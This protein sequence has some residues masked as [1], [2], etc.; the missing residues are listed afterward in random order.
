MHGRNLF[1]PPGTKN[2]MK[3]AENLQKNKESTERLLYIDSNFQRIH[4]SNKAE[5]EIF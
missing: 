5:M 2:E 3:I 1:D 4:G